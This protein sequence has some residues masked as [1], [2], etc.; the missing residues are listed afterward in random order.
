VLIILNKS[1][2]PEL[3]E[4][5]QGD[6][7]TMAKAAFNCRWRKRSVKKTNNNLQVL[8]SKLPCISL[9]KKPR[10]HKVTLSLSESHG[11]RDRCPF[12]SVIF[13]L[14]VYSLSA[15]YIVPSQV[16]P[17]FQQNRPRRPG[18]CSQSAVFPLVASLV[19]I[20]ETLCVN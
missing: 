5:Q 9:S 16:R 1:Y 11:L 19:F 2:Q 20:V 13:C 15:V 18:V 4:S 12:P 3:P 7:V 8:M 10:L 6:N 14:S 17:V